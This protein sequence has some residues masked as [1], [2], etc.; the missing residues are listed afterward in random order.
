MLDWFDHHAAVPTMAKLHSRSFVPT[1]DAKLAVLDPRPSLVDPRRSVDA[2]A[3]N[4]G[5]QGRN[6]HPILVQPVPGLV[7]AHRKCRTLSCSTP[8][9]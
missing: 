8:N 6:G 3:V 4:G 7:Q 5:W 9:G 1:G 2:A